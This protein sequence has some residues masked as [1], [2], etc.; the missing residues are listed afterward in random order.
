MLDVCLTVPARILEVIG[1][2]A[3]AS[4]GEGARWVDVSQVNVRPGDYVLV[5]GAVA[6]LVVDR[7]DAEDLLAAW[8][9]I[10]DV[11]YA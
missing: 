3:V 10:Q 4:S 11:T 2:R 8:D 6:V 9:E 5:Q 1:D 7:R